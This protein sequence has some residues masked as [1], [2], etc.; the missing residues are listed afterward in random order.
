MTSLFD[1]PSNVLLITIHFLCN[2]LLLDI[3][4]L[5]HAKLPCDSDSS[6]VQVFDPS[7]KEFMSNTL[8][9][10]GKYV[11]VQV[12]LNFRLFINKTVGIKISITLR[13]QQ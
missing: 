2:F 9:V 7:L 4:V 5:K 1:F 6:C 10:E 12:G 3:S 13:N 8:E 11:F